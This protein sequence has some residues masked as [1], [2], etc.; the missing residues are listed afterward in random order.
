MA[1][2]L[3]ETK[4][5]EQVQL[6]KG[7]NA[8]APGTA[9]LGTQLPGVATTVSEIADASGGIAPGALV[10]PDIDEELYRFNS[11]DT[12]F[13][14]LILKAKKVKTSS[15]EVEH[16][17]I[18]EP[19]SSVKTKTQLTAN[20]TSSAPL[21]LEEKDKRLAPACSTLLV[22]G[23]D[24]YAEDGKTRT[25]GQD[26]MLFVTGVD[27]STQSPIVRAVN[28]PKDNPSDEYCKLVDI[29]AGTTI[30]ILSNAMYETQK[31]VDPDAIIPQGKLIYLQKR[32]MNQVVSDYFDAQKK[33]IPFA[34]AIIAEQAI[35]NFKAKANRTMWFGRKSK[36]KV[37]VP[38]MG[39]QYAYTMEGARWQITKELQH[40]GKWTVE[41]VIALAKMFFT[42]EDVPST[43]I[44]LAGKNF[45]EAIQCIDYSKHPEIT[46]TTKENAVGWKVTNI[47]TVFGDIEIKREPTFDKM[48]RSNSAAL[49]G[50]GRLVHYTYANEHTFNDRIEGE[51][52][53]RSGIIVWDAVA[54]KGSCHIWIDGDGDARSDSKSLGLRMWD[55]TDAPQGGELVTGAVYYLLQDC[56]SINAAAVSGTM[57]QW[58]GSAWDMYAG[59]IKMS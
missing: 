45:L 28:G 19:R 2:E 24:G 56:K 43:A 10:V 13:L 1:Q 41:K 40:T 52:A 51:E 5:G 17:M 49:I 16:F 15:P 31:N 18:D 37:N 4:A 33:R 14:G 11:E 57:W 30:Y 26:L 58:T 29:P 55:K 8:P 54:L 21:P 6:V 50:M 34:R 9:G 20:D 23:V 48:G 22:S 44:L 12:P 25:P 42:G 3:V 53:T 7:S 35:A 46:I 47:H 39:M 38:G 32:G 36:F 27:Q 59:E